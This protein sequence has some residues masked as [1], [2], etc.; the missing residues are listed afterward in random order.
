M[1]VSNADVVE[2]PVTCTVE[3]GDQAA[4]LRIPYTIAV[5][6]EVAP[7]LKL[8]IYDELR[9]RLRSQVRV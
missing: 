7:G 8:P 2:I 9:A 5:S 3:S 6:L 1:N 4:V